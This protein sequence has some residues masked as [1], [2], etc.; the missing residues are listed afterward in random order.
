MRQI[1][2]R[3]KCRIYRRR[4]QSAVV[5]VF[6]IVGLFTVQ[7]AQ[8]PKPRFEVASVKYRGD[9]PLGIPPTKA[10]PNE[11]YRTETVEVFIRLA[12]GLHKT[13]V[14]G[15]PDW[16]RKGF[17]QIH[18]KGADTLT[19]PQ[20]YLM[21]QSLLEDRFK[22]IVR[23][24][25]R[26]IEAHN[27]VLARTDG[28]V[29]PKLSQC[30]TSEVRSPGPAPRSSNL[31]RGICVSSAS[32]ASAAAG[33]MNAPVFD[34]TGLM[35]LWTY[36]IYYAQAAPPPGRPSDDSLL[37]FE[38]AVLQELGLKLEPRRG[39]VDVLVIESVERPTEN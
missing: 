19:G 27:L 39:P 4:W 28:R 37:R 32:I 24:E 10:S 33:P 23:K 34:N 3:H 18:A 11:F 25:Q 13:Q 26:E 30:D 14:I 38:G 21:L 12:Y 8:I 6:V 36:W 20:M 31:F 7:A 15:G 29:G 9:Q 17:F 35:G 1:L 22:L 2:T 5:V 16:I